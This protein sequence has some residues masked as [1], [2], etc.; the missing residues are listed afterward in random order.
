[1]TWW[2][3]GTP[4]G[5]EISAL[6]WDYFSWETAYGVQKLEEHLGVSAPPGSLPLGQVVFE[7]EA[8]RVVPGDGEPGRPGGRPGA[9]RDLGPARGD[10]PA[11]CLP[12]V[13]GEGG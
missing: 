13:A 2:R 7:P 1:M 4:H 6:G 8:I 5:A 9:G 12:A 10:D 11:G 3:W